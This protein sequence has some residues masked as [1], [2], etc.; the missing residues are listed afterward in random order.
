MREEGV[1][2]DAVPKAALSP[3]RRSR[4]EHLSMIKSAED[5]GRE[6]EERTSWEPSRVKALWGDRRL[7]ESKAGG[8]SRFSP[9]HSPVSH[10]LR[11]KKAE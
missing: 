4:K 5:Q 8:E 6:T 2:A 1:Q 10:Y 11:G 7:E 3:R 9:P